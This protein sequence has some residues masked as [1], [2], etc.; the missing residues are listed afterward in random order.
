MYIIIDA[1]SII[2]LIN[3]NSGIGMAVAATRVMANESDV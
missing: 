1:I 2:L 3:G